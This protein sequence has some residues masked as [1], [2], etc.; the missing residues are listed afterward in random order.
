MIGFCFAFFS[1]FLSGGMFFVD[2]VS[3]LRRVIFFLFLPSFGL[4]V[5]MCVCV[6]MSQRHYGGL[7]IQVFIP[8]H[9]LSDVVKKKKKKWCNLF[10]TPILIKPFGQLIFKCD[11]WPLVYSTYNAYHHHHYYFNL[12]PIL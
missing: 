4:A 9:L 1:Y 11:E 10:P 5:C 3:V 12:P 7:F 8:S 6:C 2:L